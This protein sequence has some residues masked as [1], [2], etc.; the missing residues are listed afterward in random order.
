MC[1]GVLGSYPDYALL[2][3]PSFFLFVVPHFNLEHPL[4]VLSL[5]SPCPSITPSYPRFT[6]HLKHLLSPLP[7]TLPFFPLLC[8]ISPPTHSL[9][10]QASFISYFLV[11][12][13]SPSFQY[14]LSSFTSASLPL[15]SSL[16]HSLLLSAS[17]FLY[18]LPFPSRASPS[19][20]SPF[21]HAGSLLFPLSHSL[22]HTSSHP[23]ARTCY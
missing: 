4:P 9:T 1:E 16:I 14:F 11:S 17:A 21:A 19:S 10:L 6:A 3:L 18:L 2:R 5:L 8:L 20:P 7:L 23:P 22:P 13:S 12:S 15:H